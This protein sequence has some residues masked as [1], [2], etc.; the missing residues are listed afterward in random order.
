MLNTVKAIVRKK[1][2]ELEEPLNIPDG[3]KLLVVILE[4]DDDKFWQNAGSSS[5][6]KI[7]K[8]TEDDVY[9]KLIKK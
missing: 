7:W 8:N 2:I 3:T 5:L 4:E 1:R 6:D 9:A